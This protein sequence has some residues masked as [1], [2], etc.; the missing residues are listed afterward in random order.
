MHM[1]KIHKFARPSL[2][3]SGIC[4]PNNFTVGMQ[5]TITLAARFDLLL[6]T[7]VIKGILPE[8]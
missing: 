3:K 4:I 1:R 5:V 8:Q 2:Q 6:K 7:L